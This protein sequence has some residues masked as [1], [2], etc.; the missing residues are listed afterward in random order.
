M[1]KQ[2]WVIS[3]THFGH[4]NIAEV[5]T[6]HSG[7]RVRHFSSVD[8]MDAVMIDNWN[9]TVKPSDHVWHLGDVCIARWPLQKIIPQ[10]HGHLR[11][12]RGNHDIY[13]TKEYLAAGFEEIRGMSVLHD[14]L[15]THVPVHPRSV[16]RFLGNVHGHIHEQDAYGPE[17][18]NVSVE[19][20]NYTPVAIEDLVAQMKR[21]RGDRPFVRHR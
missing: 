16:E 19:K 4:T 15:F 8:E 14:I 6:D 12:I 5:F 1:A 3:D 13:K 11:L 20:I 18:I 2:I 7:N 21:Q 17:Y 10:L 9:R